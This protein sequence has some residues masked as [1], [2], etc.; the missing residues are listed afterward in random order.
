MNIKHVTSY[1]F[2][3][4]LHKHTLLKNCLAWKQPY[5]HRELQIMAENPEQ[6]QQ[7]S[8][9][10]ALLVRFCSMAGGRVMCRAL[11]P[12]TPAHLCGWRMASSAGC[13]VP[14]WSSSGSP[15]AAELLPARQ[16]GHPPWHH[17]PGTCT[18][19]SHT[20][21]SHTP[22]HLESMKAE[23]TQFFPPSVQRCSEQDAPVLSWPGCS[24]HI[25]TLTTAFFCESLLD[26]V[27]QMNCCKTKTDEIRAPS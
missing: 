9:L 12:G 22:S 10:T 17:H 15:G 5:Q 23:N 4:D 3:W 20:Q 18:Q 25:L 2:K 1:C 6:Q 13:S 14:R 21:A 27:L 11:A 8:F 16:A 26:W 7:L 19:P 24:Q